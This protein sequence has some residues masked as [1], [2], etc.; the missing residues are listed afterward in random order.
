MKIS[1]R[2][3]LIATQQELRR[4]LGTF[5]GTLHEALREQVAKDLAPRDDAKRK[6]ESAD[7][8]RSASSTTSRSKSA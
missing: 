4:N 5:Q 7:G 1:E 6:L 2:D 8:P 3:Q